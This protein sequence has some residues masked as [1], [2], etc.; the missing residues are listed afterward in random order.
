MTKPHVGD[1]PEPDAQAPAAAPAGELMAYD[2]YIDTQLHTARRQ[3]RTV[4]IAVGL[5]TLAAGTL[6]Y[7]ILAAVVDHWVLP[8]GLP[9]LGRWLAW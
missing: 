4:D 5:T 1:K 8:G 3:V 2:E 7:F 6:G 9:A